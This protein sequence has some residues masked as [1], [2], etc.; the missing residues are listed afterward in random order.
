[1]KRQ[2]LIEVLCFCNTDML[3]KIRAA[4]KSVSNKFIK[5]QLH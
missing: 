2:S 5:V 4:I 3:S 1:M